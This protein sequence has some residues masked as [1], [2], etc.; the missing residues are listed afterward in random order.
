MVDP[1]QFNLQ[2]ECSSMADMAQEIVNLNGFSDGEMM[3]SL[4]YFVI[5]VLV[6]IL[7]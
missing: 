5:G 7:C 4:V 1:S 3:L 2:I 6:C